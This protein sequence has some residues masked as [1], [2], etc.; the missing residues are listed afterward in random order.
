MRTQGFRLGAVVALAT[1]LGC[2]SIVDL[3][4]DYTLVAD[5]DNDVCHTAAAYGAACTTETGTGFCNANEQCVECIEGPQCASGVCND[6]RC[7]DP[8]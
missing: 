5:D 7:I 2:T 1:W 4:R 3:D 6:E 8:A